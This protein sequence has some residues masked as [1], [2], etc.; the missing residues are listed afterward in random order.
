VYATDETTLKMPSV[1]KIFAYSAALCSWKPCNTPTDLTTDEVLRTAFSTIATFSCSNL[2]SLLAADVLPEHR[3][4]FGDIFRS[5]GTRCSRHFAHVRSNPLFR[6][7]RC[8][9]FPVDPPWPDVARF[10]SLCRVDVV[11]V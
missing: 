11:S 4:S 5:P 6:G 9:V 3:R 10:H 1:L 7:R 8:I 2:E